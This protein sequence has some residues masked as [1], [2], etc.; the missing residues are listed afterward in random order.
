MKRSKLVLEEVSGD[1]EE[2]MCKHI[3]INY[4]ISPSMWKVSVKFTVQHT[5]R[6]ESFFPESFSDD[7]FHCLF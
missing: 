4:I 6:F 2:N 3:A 7:H 5:L 1:G